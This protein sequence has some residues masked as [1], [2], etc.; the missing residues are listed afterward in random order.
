MMLY[1]ETTLFMFDMPYLPF[2]TWMW[3]QLSIIMEHE[4]AILHMSIYF[5]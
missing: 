2:S 5:I 3:I 1:K 4:Q